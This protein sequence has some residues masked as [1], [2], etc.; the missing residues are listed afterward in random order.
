MTSDGL[1]GYGR[2]GGVAGNE[3]VPDLAV[4]LPAP[5]DHGLTYTFHIRSGIRYSN[6]VPLRATDFRR[7]LERAYEVG[8]GPTGDLS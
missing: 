8:G 4:A 5:T 6:G 3:L 1:V 2:V 7:G